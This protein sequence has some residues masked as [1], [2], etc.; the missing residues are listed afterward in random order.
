MSWLGDGALCVTSLDA[1]EAL[2][3]PSADPHAASSVTAVAKPVT[4]AIILRARRDVSGMIP[5]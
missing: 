5:P 3:D 2:S 1:A 4:A